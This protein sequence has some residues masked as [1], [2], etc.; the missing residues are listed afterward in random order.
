MNTRIKELRKILKLTQDRFAKSINISR[1]NL[2]AIENG[3]I[4]ITDRNVKMICSVHDVNEDWLRTGNGEM[5]YFSNEDDELD[6]LIGSFYA[7]DDDFK[8]KVIKTML[9]WN[10]EDWMFIKRFVDKI[11]D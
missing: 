11:K 5:F 7:E 4:N 1:S 6:M 3:T 10:E 2:S 9:S 8:K